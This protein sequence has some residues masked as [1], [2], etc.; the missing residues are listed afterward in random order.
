MLEWTVRLSNGICIMEDPLRS[1]ICICIQ[2]ARRSKCQC[3]YSM[4]F[5]LQKRH[6]F[7]YLIRSQSSLHPI[8][9]ASPPS[10][11]AAAS[12]RPPIVLL[13]AFRFHSWRS[14]RSGSLSRLQWLTPFPGFTA[15]C[16]PRPADWPSF[17]YCLQNIFSK[18]LRLSLF[19]LFNCNL[20][21]MIDAISKPNETNF[22]WSMCRHHHRRLFDTIYSI[23]GSTQ[24]ISLC[25]ISNNNQPPFI[26]SFQ[27]KRSDFN[28]LR[29]QFRKKK[30][31]IQTLG[32]TL[33]STVSGETKLRDKTIDEQQVV[34]FFYNQFKNSKFF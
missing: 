4:L 1:C 6:T 26:H 8:A 3:S 33:W 30:N 12:T 13:P 11:A 2:S 7:H 18:H 27:F 23:I 25:L 15:K 10:N 34:L 21:F 20:L 17:T 16:R 32:Q 31:V 28:F 19:F 29:L 24:S 22:K 5:H 9:A 14:R